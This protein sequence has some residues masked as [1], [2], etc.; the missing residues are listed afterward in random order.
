[1]IIRFIT[2]VIFILFGISCFFRKK[3]VPFWS[4]IKP[5]EVDDIKGYNLAVGK[6]WCTFGVFMEVI[7]IML[8]GVEHNT[9]EAALAAFVYIIGIFVSIIIMMLYYIMVIEKRYKKK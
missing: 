3:P 8:I 2:G 9:K 7:S 6:I 1:M 5:F 4:N